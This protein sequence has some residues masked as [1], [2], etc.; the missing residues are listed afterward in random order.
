MTTSQNTRDYWLT[1][2]SEW[3]EARLMPPQIDEAQAVIAE[4]KEENIK[5]HKMQ[6]DIEA[7][8]IVLEMQAARRE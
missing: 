6:R 1:M 5:W 3:A 8:V 7:G 2:F 4:V